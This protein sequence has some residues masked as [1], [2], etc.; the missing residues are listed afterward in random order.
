MEETRIKE[1]ENILMQECEKHEKDC[2]TCPYSK[3]CDEYAR[4]KNL[5]ISWI[6]INIVIMAMSSTLIVF[7]YG[8]IYGLFA[9]S[10]AQNRLVLARLVVG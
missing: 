9:H 8:L 10:T 4:L 3:E 7:F 1:L 5:I 2:T 6:T